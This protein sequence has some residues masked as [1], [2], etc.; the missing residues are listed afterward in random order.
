MGASP[1]LLGQLPECR[2]RDGG[3]GKVGRFRSRR[4]LMRD[5]LGAQLHS[6]VEKPTAL[7]E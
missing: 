3:Q 6:E 7:L 4:I 2:D 1:A 5:Q